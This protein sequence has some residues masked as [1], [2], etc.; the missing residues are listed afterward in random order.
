MSEL[1]VYTAADLEFEFAD[2]RFPSMSNDEAVDL[3]LE[4]VGVIDERELNLAVDIVL[5][6]DLVFRAK[7]GKTGPENDRWLAG[8]AAVARMFGV[9]SLL[10]RRRH[11]EAGTPFTDL[12]IDHETHKAHGGSVPIIVGDVV[13][14][15]ITVSGEPDVIDHATA[16]E[17]IRR[18]LNR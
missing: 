1:P 18:F 9:P 3:G 14:G 4:A 2:L 17:A 6:G 15:T 11:E 12:D 13:V 5:G 16:V 10:V 8:K 7:L